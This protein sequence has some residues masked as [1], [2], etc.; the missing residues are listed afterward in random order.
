MTAAWNGDE[1]VFGRKWDQL[2][3]DGDRRTRIEFGRR[4]T[5]QLNDMARKR[6]VAKIGVGRSVR[7]RLELAD[8]GL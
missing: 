1:P 6:K 5:M 8:K 2:S 4:I 7:W 3:F